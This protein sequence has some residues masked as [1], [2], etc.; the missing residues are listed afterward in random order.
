MASRNTNG[1]TEKVIK[2]AT[3]ESKRDLVWRYKFGNSMYR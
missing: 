1:D 2:Y 3:L